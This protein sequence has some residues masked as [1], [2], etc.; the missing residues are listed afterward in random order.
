MSRVPL[1]SPSPSVLW[2]RDRDRG[3]G[4]AIVLVELTNIWPKSP[5]ASPFIIQIMVRYAM[6][7]SFIWNDH[8]GSLNSFFRT[9]FP[10]RHEKI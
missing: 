8:M 6:R 2:D 9:Q 4:R 1:L 3:W 10:I 7:E 5:D